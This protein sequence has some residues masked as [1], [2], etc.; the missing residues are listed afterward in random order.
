MLF[1]YRK[2]RD[3]S[4]G[5]GPLRAGIWAMLLL[6]WP[7]GGA[8]FETEACLACHSHPLPRAAA[9]SPKEYAR[10][11]HGAN[12]CISCHTDI[13]AIPH[14]P[15]LKSVSCG[16]CHRVETAVYLNSDHGRALSRGI[17]EA[18]T[19][20][21]C[22]G[23]PHILRSARDIQSPSH[24]LNIAGTCGACHAD[25]KKMAGYR[26]TQRKP[27]ETYELSIHG[28][29]SR[30]GRL[31]AATCPDCHG[32]HDLHGTANPKS[33]IFRSGIPETCGK[34][35]ENV[36]LVFMRSVHG[37]AI[38]EGIREAPV[39]TD[40]HGEHVILPVTD[41]ASSVF[42]TSITGTCSN[43]H[44]SRKI[45]AK[46]GLPEDRL[47]TF[48]DSYH[49]MAVRL[50]DVRAA[51]CASCHG[52]HDVLPAA[53]PASSINPANLSHTCGKCHPG[54]QLKKVEGPIHGGER[55]DEHWLVRAVRI[56]YLILIP[57]TIGGMLAHNFA[58]YLRKAVEGMARHPVGV[59]HETQ[60]R[61]TLNERIQHFFLLAA[62]ITLAH[63][64]F[65][66][67]FPEAWWSLPYRLGGGEVFR[68]AVHR[69]TA[70]VFI[71]SAL[72][73]TAYILGTKRGRDLLFNRFFPKLHDAKDA[74]KLALFNFGVRQE[75]PHLAYPSYI[76][77]AEYWA[78]IWGSAVMIGSGLL[79]VFTDFTLRTFPLWVSNLAT[80]IHLLE[81]IL[82]CLSIL[83]WHAY[84]TVFDPDI[85]PMNWT[86]IVGR[87]R[88]R[89]KSRK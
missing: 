3:F 60:V 13:D 82:A 27:I 87:V 41:S 70:L 71:L 58:D 45:I 40:C 37:T 50:G 29:A 78:L 88:L 23:A 63:S 59:E 74:L 49:G 20:T 76:E 12:L 54:T 68:R 34:C 53:D 55:T 85:Y 24:R 77:K 26:L 66:L 6:T 44:T 73:H 32:T 48:Q 8:A 21:S 31:N 47:S 46:F 57:L 52:W 36:R 30:A 39:C 65:A 84:W 7:H 28:Q 62:F 80:L 69:W 35:H 43:C 17:R 79:L 19:C 4:A 15:K 2:F 83:A 5:T 11:V 22:H 10:S 38:K 25:E 51:N 75:R 56:V 81:A 64:G 1:L 67:E 14:A 16:D 18:A 9:V 86:W 42:P 61:M 89:A 33:K 72:Y